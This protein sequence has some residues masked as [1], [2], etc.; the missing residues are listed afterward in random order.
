[1]IILNTTIRRQKYFDFP[2]QPKRC[3]YASYVL[4]WLGP[5]SGKASKL[6]SYSLITNACASHRTNDTLGSHGDNQLGRVD[7]LMIT[8]E[9]K[10]SKK[11]MP[12]TAL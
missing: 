10:K 6:P 9:K 2:P 8:P 3:K 11:D 4:Y 5:M 7:G 1:M 12:G